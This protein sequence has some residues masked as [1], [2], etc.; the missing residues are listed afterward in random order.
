MLTNSFDSGL[1]EVARSLWSLAGGTGRGSHPPT[2]RVLAF[3]GGRGYI[4]TGCQTHALFLFVLFQCV[5][6]VFPEHYNV[7]FYIVKTCLSRMLL[8]VLDVLIVLL[9]N[10]FRDFCFSTRHVYGLPVSISFTACIYRISQTFTTCKEMCS[11]QL[12]YHYLL[13]D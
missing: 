10:P 7:L 5:F 12:N 13:S 3:G 4:L 11:F 8:V 9:T 2:P 1:A 6:V